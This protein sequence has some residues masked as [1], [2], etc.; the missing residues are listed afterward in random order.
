MALDNGPFLHVLVLIDWKSANHAAEATTLPNFALDRLGDSRAIFSHLGA[1]VILV[2]GR[3]RNPIRVYRWNAIPPW[4]RSPD[5]SPLAATFEWLFHAQTA[6]PEQMVLA[7]RYPLRAMRM[8][9]RAPPRM[10]SM[11][12]RVG[13]V[14]Q[15]AA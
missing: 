5:A 13:A 15:H 10:L 3:T 7:Y 1:P 8:Q 11:E 6:A 2:C 12:R 4:R 14:P 9:S